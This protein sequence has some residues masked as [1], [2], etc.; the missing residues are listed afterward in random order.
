M[1]GAKPLLVL[2]QTPAFHSTSPGSAQVWATVPNMAAWKTY[3][4][5][6]VARYGTR[7]DYEI[8]PEADISSNWAGTPQEL[9]KLVAAAGKIIHAAAPHATVVSPA[10]VLRLPF[11]RRWMNKFFAQKVGGR[12][13]GQYV[14]AVGIDPYPMQKGTPEDSLALI[15]KARHVLASHNVTA[16]LWNVEINYGVAGGG[17]PITHHSSATK[18]ASYVVRTYVLNA[19]AGIRR[20]YWL[21]WGR[22]LTMD[23]QMVE[24]DG[25]T[26]T[27]AGRAYVQVE[28]WLIGQQVRAC[29][30][31][32]HS[33]VYTCTLSRSGHPSWIYW[34]PTGTKTVRAPKGARFVQSLTGHVSHTAHRKKIK[35]TSSPVLVYH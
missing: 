31:D 27:A 2:G 28:K 21:G 22:F 20:V 11:E 16:P 4:Q 29:P 18:Q 35:V 5:R 19:A 32:R 9:A 34:V 13:I 30:R 12:R 14:D 6:V 8:W 15:T 33:H 10:M 17:V 24:T 7:L 26:P 25:V 23:V 3:V 1:H